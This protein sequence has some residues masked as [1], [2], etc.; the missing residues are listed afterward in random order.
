MKQNNN[1]N[2]NLLLAISKEE[3]VD[4]IIEL[5]EKLEQKMKSLKKEL[6]KKMR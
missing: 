1:R 5:D 6:M 4:K 3:L 2:K